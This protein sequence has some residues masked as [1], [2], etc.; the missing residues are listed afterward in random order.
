MTKGCHE[1][2]PF[3]I[4][5]RIES[6]VLVHIIIILL[7][8]TTGDIVHPLLIVKIPA[9]SLL[10]TLLELQAWLPTEFLLQLG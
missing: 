7:V 6:T 1:R 4:S 3:I 10:Y 5:I 2:Q 9:Y 8:L